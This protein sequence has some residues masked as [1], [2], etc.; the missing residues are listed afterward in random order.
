MIAMAEYRGKGLSRE[1]MDVVE[2]FSVG[3]YDR[4]VIIA[5]IK[6]D[7]IM[8]IKFFEKIGY[9]FVQDNVHHGEM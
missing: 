7:N 1:V 8:S 3:V 9:G 4:N 6:K 2:L 5:K